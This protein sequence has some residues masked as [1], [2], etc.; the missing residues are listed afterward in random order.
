MDSEEHERMPELNEQQR[1]RVD[2]LTE[3]ELQLLD[4]ALIEQ[5]ESVRW[6]KLARVVSRALDKTES[7]V[8][9]VP[10]IFLAARVRRLVEF[11]ALEAQ[12]DLY[13]MRFSEV[14]LRSR[15]C[16]EC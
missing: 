8:P 10:D 14:R 13:L 15:R 6:R 16:S 11:G 5:V 12:G 7:T 3:H 2:R 9:D 4:D 1:Q